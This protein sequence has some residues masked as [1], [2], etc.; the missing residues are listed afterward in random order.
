MNDHDTPAGHPDE[1]VEHMLSSMPPPVN[2]IYRKPAHWSY[3]SNAPYFREKFGLKMKSILDAMMIDGQDRIFRYSRWP[4]LSKDTIYSRLTQGKMYLIHKLDT[5]D[6]K[7]RRFCECLSIVKIKNVGVRLSIRKDILE[8]EKLKGTI[9]D[10]EPDVINPETTCD[11]RD[12]MHNWLDASSKNEELEPFYMSNIVLTPGQISDIELEIV[13]MPW[14]MGRV[15][16]K[17]IKLVRI[18]V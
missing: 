18:K 8:M 5:D 7:Y 9:E 17:S 14:V 2:N 10:F 1:V 3:K 6:Q 16:E 11:W 15:T 4:E 13:N 12:R